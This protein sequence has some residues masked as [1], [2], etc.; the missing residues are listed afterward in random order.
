[1]TK[2]EF[3]N[4]VENNFFGEVTI[5]TNEDEY[6]IED[7]ENFIGGIEGCYTSELLGN[8]AYSNLKDISEE[9]YDYIVNTLK[10]TIENVG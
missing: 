3:V 5:V 7:S 9:V 1:M 6:S 10:E 8:V 4:E 2:Q